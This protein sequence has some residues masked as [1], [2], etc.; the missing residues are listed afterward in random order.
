AAKSDPA[1]P[2]R[3]EALSARQPGSERTAATGSAARGA[4][5]FG[6]LGACANSHGRPSNLC[7]QPAARGE[8]LLQRSRALWRLG[9]FG[10]LRLVL[11]AARSGDQ[12]RLAALL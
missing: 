2:V 5:G 3:P 11:A 6:T 4:A 7:Q 9:G 10:G 1:I 8:L 12:P